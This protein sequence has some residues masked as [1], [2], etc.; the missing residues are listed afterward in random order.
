MKKSLVLFLVLLFYLPSISIAYEVIEVKNGGGIEGIVRFTGATIPKDEILAISSDVKYCGKSIPAE[1][2]LIGPD[3]GIK[4]VVVFIE[5]INTGKRIPTE[6]IVV[7]NKKCRFEPHVSVGFKGNDFTTTNSDPMFHN[8]HTYLG[9]RTMYNLGLSKMDSFATKRLGKT[10]IMEIT[11]DAHP[12]MRGYAYILDHP[13]STVTNEKGE[14]VIKD[15]PPGIYNLVAWHEAL[16]NV[17]IANIKVEAGKS[18]KI[19]LEYK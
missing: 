10:G 9:D 8:V 1:K 19:K 13:Y 14:F 11:C 7:T 17:K 12:W 3:R 16:G 4:N 2:F 5:N 6:A 15:I 18:S